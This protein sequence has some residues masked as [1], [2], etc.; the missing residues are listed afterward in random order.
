MVFPHPH[1]EELVCYLKQLR[2]EII[3]AFRVLDSDCFFSERRPWMLVK[4]KEQREEMA[5]FKG[6]VFEKAAVNWSGVG[7][8]SFPMGERKGLFLQLESV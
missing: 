3:A 5:L 7:G 6:R 4:E 1:R 2:E 8:P